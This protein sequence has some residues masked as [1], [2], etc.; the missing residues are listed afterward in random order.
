MVI[1]TEG[2]PT[3]SSLGSVNGLAQ[4]V[5]SISRSLGPSFASSMFA[6]SLQRQLAGGDAVYYI[7][8]VIV[9]MGI[10]FAFMLPGN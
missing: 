8:M 9:A 2:A 4:A 3:R 5:G 7:M 1:L 10:R 6:L